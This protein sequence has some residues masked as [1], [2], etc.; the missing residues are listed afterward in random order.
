M[1]LVAVVT[2][3]GA[4]LTIVVLALYLLR[5]SMMLRQVARGLTNVTTGLKLVVQKTEPAAGVVADINNDLIAVDERLR[6]VLQ[7]AGGRAAAA[8]PM[9]GGPV[10][11][12][13]GS[14]AAA[15]SS[16]TVRQGGEPPDPA[17]VG[18][19]PG[20]ADVVWGIRR[21]PSMASTPQRFAALFGLIY[22]GIG[23][24]GFF[25]TGFNDLTEF[26]GENLFWVFGVTPFHNIVHIGVGGLW[27]LAAFLLTPPAAEGLNFAI[28]GVYVLAA[29]L[30]YLGQLEFLGILRGTDPDNFLHLATGVVSLLFAGLIGGLIGTRGSRAERTAAARGSHRVPA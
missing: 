8:P 20:P 3:I 10:S 23:V 9:R 26:T 5:L 13:S 21:A 28:A 6:E 25:V 12:R 15:V 14:L 29:I 11:M 1:P 2:L 19:E 17:P 30:G 16:S 22:V 7:R 24:I 4:A 27:L 18:G